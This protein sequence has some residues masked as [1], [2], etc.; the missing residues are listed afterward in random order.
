M[1]PYEE[2]ANKI[3]K[4]A[5][6]AAEG[7]V[8]QNDLRWGVVAALLEH[9]DLPFSGLK[10]QLDIH[11]QSLSDALE[12]LQIGGLVK[13]E[14]REETGGRYSGYYS[15]TQFGLNILDG[16][17]KATRPKYQAEDKEPTFA[18]APNIDGA[19]VTAFE[20]EKVSEMTKVASTKNFGRDTDQQRFRVHP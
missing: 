7:L 16:F 9:G 4:E 19:Q 10:D 15:I 17:Y 14:A 5:R 6:L 11:Q 3:P 12:A 13:K 8:G 2:Y 18:Y 1:E 20:V